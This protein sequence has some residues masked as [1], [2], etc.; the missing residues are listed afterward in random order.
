MDTSSSIYKRLLHRTTATLAKWG[1]QAYERRQLSQLDTRELADLG[2]SQGD[3]MA[4]IS[5]PFWRD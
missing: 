5:K 3:R 2:I 4:E 1:R